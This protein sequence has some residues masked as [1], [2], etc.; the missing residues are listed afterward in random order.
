MHQSVERDGWGW[1]KG[2]PR[3]WDLIQEYSLPVFLD[4]KNTAP[5]LFRGVCGIVPN[6]DAEG[7]DFFRSRRFGGDRAN[8]NAE[9]IVRL[10]NFYLKVKKGN[11]TAVP[12]PV[13]GGSVDVA[14]YP[15]LGRVGRHT[16]ARI[17]GEDSFGTTCRHGDEPRWASRCQ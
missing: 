17:S 2:K 7:G 16:R 15:L 3:T 6:P 10:P 13:G 8:K 1:N 11:V 4:E 12:N 14:H 9:D 5:P